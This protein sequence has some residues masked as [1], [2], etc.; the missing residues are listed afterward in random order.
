[1]VSLRL[2]L[3]IAIFVAIGCAPQRSPITIKPTPAAASCTP[4]DTATWRSKEAA[5]VRARRERFWWRYT[6][7]DTVLVFVHGIRATWQNTWMNDCGAFWPDLV[8]A[9]P[10]LAHVGV[11]MVGYPTSH[12]DLGGAGTSPPSTVAGWILDSLTRDTTVLGLQF[13]GPRLR[14]GGTAVRRRPALDRRHVVFVSH[15]LGGIVTTEVL[16]ELARRETLDSIR[17]RRVVS[18][19]AVAVPLRGAGA[20]TTLGCKYLTVLQSERSAT[21]WCAF[22][23]KENAYLRTVAAD[24]GKLI[25]YG[26]RVKPICET[27]RTSGVMIVPE[28]QCASVGEGPDYLETD[29]TSIAKPSSIQDIRHDKLA[30]FVASGATTGVPIRKVA[31][32]AVA[33]QRVKSVR[34]DTVVALPSTIGQAIAATG[35]WRGLLE[36]PIPVRDTDSRVLIDSVDVLVMFGAEG[37][38]PSLEYQH[39]TPT[40][41]RSRVLSVPLQRISCI[42]A[43]APQSAHDSSTVAAPPPSL[44][45]RVSFTGLMAEA[46]GNGAGSA[47]ALDRD[48]RADEFTPLDWQRISPVSGSARWSIPDSSGMVCPNGLAID[49][50]HH[51]YLRDLL[52]GDEALPDSP[53]QELRRRTGAAANGATCGVLTYR[54]FEMSDGSPLTAW[55]PI[56]R[57]CPLGGVDLRAISACI[58]RP[59]REVLVRIPRAQQIY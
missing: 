56:S 14:M 38:C 13:D 31:A 44:I 5:A 43:A 45:A 37:P 8:L 29:H 52:Q 35:E 7:S 27:L 53:L 33:R 26:V 30:T 46:T 17:T 34:R 57:P 15:S 42:G 11:Y 41:R 36:L 20:L 10:R 3:P 58:S 6:D 50:P 39:E 22:L 25:N 48:G 2:A 4:S 19:F 59:G 54:V 24:L 47:T 16:S 51:Q 32:T 12:A 1:M 18:L 28:G 55:A 21:Q 40:E 49:R 9:D 23:G